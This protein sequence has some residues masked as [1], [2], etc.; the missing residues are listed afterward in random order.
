MK[1]F[2]SL[3]V[4]GTNR[5][6]PVRGRP[7]NSGLAAIQNTVR[8]MVHHGKGTLPPPLWT[9]S[10]TVVKTLPSLVLRT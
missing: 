9:E 8:F 4:D 5:V 6:L 10:Q 7:I 3:N 1:S 2:K